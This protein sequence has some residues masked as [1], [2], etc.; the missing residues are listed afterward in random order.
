MKTIIK[1]IFAIMIL[2]SM[3]SCT[4][5][6]IGTWNVVSY[7]SKSSN[8]QSNVRLNN[9][10]YMT[11]RASGDGDKYIK[12][13]VLGVDKKDST[14]LHWKANDKFI[15]I[16]S[17]GSDFSKTWLIIENKKKSQ[18]WKSTDGANQIQTIEL[19]KQ[20]E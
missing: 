4:P 11:L 13:N 3:N 19:K 10:G 14:D 5:K 15:T 12:Y 2:L 17:E 18:L 20:I 6:L 1:S 7:E 16:E 9:I 8:N